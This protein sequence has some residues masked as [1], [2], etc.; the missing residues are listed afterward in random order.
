MTNVKGETAGNGR[1]PFHYFHDINGAVARVAITFW[2]S[3]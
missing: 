1:I 3:V 2:L